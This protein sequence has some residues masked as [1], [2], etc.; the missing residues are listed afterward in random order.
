MKLKPVIWTVRDKTALLLAL[1]EQLAGNAHMSFEGDLKAFSILKF[2]ASGY[3]ETTVLKRHTIWPKQDFVVVP[4]EA[5]SGPA[6]L[7]AIGGRVPRRIMHFQIEKA[8]VLEFGAYDSF[9]PE[10]L[11]FG[12]ALQGPF[13]ESAISRG[14]V[15]R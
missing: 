9:D 8:G 6:I 3:T 7:N 2:P 10:C 12:P 5:S 1:M 15:T 11:F 14:L 13:Q 4:L